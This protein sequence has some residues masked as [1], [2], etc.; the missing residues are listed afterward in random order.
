MVLF[1]K[2][3][4]K[5]IRDMAMEFSN[6]QMV[7]NMKDTGRITKLTA[8]AHFI[9]LMEMSLKVIGKMTKQ[10][11]TV[12]ISMLMVQDMKVIGKMTSKKVME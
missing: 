8:K 10:T 4:G 1:I 5:A 2:V 9:M 12:S 7:Q 6:G 3:N 11:D